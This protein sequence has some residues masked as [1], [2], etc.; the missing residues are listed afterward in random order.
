MIADGMQV[1]FDQWW[2]AAIPG[3]AILLASPALT[4]WAMACA[5]FWSRNMTDIRLT[6]R[7]SPSTIPPPGWWTTS[8]SPRQR[9]AGA[10]GRIRLRQ[11]D[12]RPGADGP[13]RKPGW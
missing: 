4:C 8:A 1:I 3:A 6:V 12:D 10:G 2:I 7:D 9:A 13:V 5:I 11:I